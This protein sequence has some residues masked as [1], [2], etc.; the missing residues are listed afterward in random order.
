MRNKSGSDFEFTEVSSVCPKPFP[1]LYEQNKIKAGDLLLRS[2]VSQ[3]FFLDD[4][5]EQHD[6]NLTTETSFK[7]TEFFFRSQ[8]NLK[9]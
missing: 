9:S 4:C 6:F 5:M 2:E 3:R 8:C 7:E 1:V